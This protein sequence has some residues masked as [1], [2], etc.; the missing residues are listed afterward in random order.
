MSTSTRVRAS[1]PRRQF[2]S[3]KERGVSE[4]SEDSD[5][6]ETRC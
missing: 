4:I 1:I 3:F 6:G 5:D 2:S